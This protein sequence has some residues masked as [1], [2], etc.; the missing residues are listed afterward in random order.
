MR[1][2]RTMGDVRNDA[3]SLLRSALGYI[4]DERDDR[5]GYD[6][7]RAAAAIVGELGL[8]LSRDG[9]P[10]YVDKRLHDA[11]ME[12]SEAIMWT[13]PTLSADADSNAET[14]ENL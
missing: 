12:L 5:R 2:M 7:I 10:I 1:T 6:H 13:T 4:L 11:L 9:A 3:L 8:G 14:R